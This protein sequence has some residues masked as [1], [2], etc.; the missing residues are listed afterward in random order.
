MRMIQRLGNIGCGYNA[1][2]FKSK[3]SVEGRGIALLTLSSSPFHMHT[4]TPDAL[5]FSTWFLMRAFKGDTTKPSFQRFLMFARQHTW[6]RKLRVTISK[7]EIYRNRWAILPRCHSHGQLYFPALRAA[8]LSKWNPP[9]QF[10]SDHI[11]ARSQ[12]PPCQPFCF[13][14]SSMRR[15]TGR[16]RFWVCQIGFSQ[17]LWFRRACA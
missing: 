6:S 14:H 11:L 17:S 15:E 12:T 8:S 7:S 13:C 10:L 4:F 3:S 16:P 5:S 2:P 9:F 1:L